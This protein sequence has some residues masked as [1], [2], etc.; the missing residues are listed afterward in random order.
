MFINPL[1]AMYG[2]RGIGLPYTEQFTKALRIV[3]SYIKRNITLYGENTDN[4]IIDEATVSGTTHVTICDNE[5]ITNYDIKPEDLTELGLRYW[6]PEDLVIKDASQGYK[7]AEKLLKGELKKD[8]PF[9]HLIA[10]NS[11]FNLLAHGIVR[12]LKD[13]VEQSFYVIES[14]LGIK[15]VNEYKEY[16]ARWKNGDF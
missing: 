15:K 5:R 11:A 10:L 14:G 13:G 1:G 8:N 2:V 9:V 3:H 16:V 6:K 12:E 4:T 7:I